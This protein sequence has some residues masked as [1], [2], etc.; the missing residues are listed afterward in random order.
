MTF[1]VPGRFIFAHLP[2][3]GGTWLRHNISQQTDIIELPVHTFASQARE[4]FPELPVVS[5]CRHPL[6]WAKS[7]FC[8]RM[9]H[10]WNPRRR[11]DEECR[12]EYLDDFLQNAVERMPGVMNQYGDQFAADH[13]IR[14]ERLVEDAERVLA[15]FGLNVVERA[16]INPRQYRGQ[17]IR[18]PRRWSVVKSQWLMDSSPYCE[19]HGYPVL[20]SHERAGLRRTD[21]HQ[22]QMGA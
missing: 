22:V 6:T 15:L 5:C 10:G 3:S 16:R 18:E 11:F 1:I 17:L 21:L 19:Q 9:A 14:F 20:I 2:K 13:T 7:Y 4:Q 12:A 8:H